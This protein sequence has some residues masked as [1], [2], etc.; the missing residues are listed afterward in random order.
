MRFG[1][2]IF[3]YHKPWIDPSTQFEDDLQLIEHL[4]RLGYDEVWIGEHHS[5]GWQNI[6]APELFLAA[7][8]QRTRNIT[9]GTGV[10]SLPYHH[11]LMLV[12]RIV[13]LSHMLKGRLLWGIG[14]GSL[15]QDAQMIGVDPLEQRR[16]T[17]E[18][19]EA[20]LALLRFDGPVTRRTDWFEIN[21]A[22]LHLRP[23]G[24]GLDIRVASQLS[25]SGP[26]LA[27]KYGT[28][29][30][31]FGVLGT[32]EDNPIAQT[33]AIAE[34]SAAAHG[35][36]V[37]RQ[38]WSALHMMHI[39]ETEQEARAQARW[40]LQDWARYML[41][42]L[43]I[44]KSD[45][46]DFDALVDELNESIFVIGTPRMARE[47]IA[48]IV[49]KSGGLGSIVIGNCEVASPRHQRDSFEL[50]AR[51]VFPH[52]TGQV[53]PRLAGVESMARF[54][55][56]GE[57]LAAAQEKARREYAAEKAEREAR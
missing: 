37:D 11:P 22:Q 29:L 31:Q 23:Y 52:F 30:F 15:A 34:E 26:R 39:A 57:K 53:A 44:V 9:L 18:A 25:P 36:T 40:G 50:L 46:D 51:E 43:P 6:A 47:R 33:W 27:G 7:A 13:Q 54:G 3:P 24:G 49:E 45:P 35:Q 2:Q 16:M 10:S 4:D 21:D 41:T 48:T 17:E 14:A 42:I 32:V 8:G 5:T 56:T 19:L 55:A 1:V 28:G 12:D 38:R 20:I